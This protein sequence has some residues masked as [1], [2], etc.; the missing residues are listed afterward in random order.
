LTFDTGALINLERRRQDIWKVFH[1]AY[2]NDEI[3]IVPAIVLAE[4]WRTGRHEKDRARILRLVIVEP[5]I[6]HVAR[7]A[8]HALSIVPDAGTVDAVVM[9][10]ASLRDD[11]V[12]TS[13]PDH[14]ERLRAAFP[15]VLVERA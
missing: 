12:Y 5:L 2:E 6:D 4:W 10:S 14:L 15:S 7:L 13:D 3:V 9:A 8:G 11:V 1:T